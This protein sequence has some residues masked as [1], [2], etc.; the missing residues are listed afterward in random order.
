[1][2]GK[3][4]VL[5][6]RYA[7]LVLAAFWMLQAVTG[8]I[9]VFHWEFDDWGVK[10][11]ARKL[12]PAALGATIDA[13]P[14]TH[15]GSS[16]IGVYSSAGLP[17]RFDLLVQNPKG[18]IDAWRTDGAGKVLRKRPWDYDTPRTGVFQIITTIHQTL[19][20]GDRGKW[21][22]GFSG[23]LLL[24]NIGLGLK[25][26]WPRARQWK[27]ALLPAKAKAAPMQVWSWHRAAG[28]WL[29]APAFVSILFGVLLALEA[30]VFAWFPA[31]SQTPAVAMAKA[32]PQGAPVGTAQAISLAMQRFPG[33][34]LA[35]IG[36]ASADEPWIKVRVR[37][38]GELNRAFGRTAVYVS[39]RSGRVIGVYD[40]KTAP[41]STW[42]ADNLASLH[43]G[44]AGG[45]V[46]RFIVLIIGL[47]LASMTGLGV[48]LWALR[49]KMRKPKAA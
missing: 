36:L 49:R 33:A 25:L 12:D 34:R 9:L 2:I 48:T 40:P 21:F 3:L 39:S 5:V 44:E 17:D 28:L 30:V 23:L 22:L 6:H 37:Q 20:A 42:L 32:E 29:G 35:A 19:L 27:R 46:G 15:P 11:P 45:L 8:A 31:P 18:G 1:M 13:I 41:P 4:I 47:W 16:L 24:T 38:D 7:S 26:A 10:A 14:R 43:T